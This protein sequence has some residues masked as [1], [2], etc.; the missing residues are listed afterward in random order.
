MPSSMR[1]SPSRTIS[2]VEIGPGLGALTRPLL[3]RIPH[4]HVVELDRDIIARLKETWP[5]ER[6]SIHEGDALKFD[7]N[8]IARPGAAAIQ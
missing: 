3:D 1:F 7:F 5:P 2:L 8:V 4:L 6:L